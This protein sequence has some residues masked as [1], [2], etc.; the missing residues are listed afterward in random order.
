MIVFHTDL[1]N[2]L[3]YSYKHNIGVEKTCVEVYQGRNISFMTNESIK[4]LQYINKKILVVPTTTRTV[5]QY[6]R[7]NMGIGT[8]RYALVCNGGVLLVDGAEDIEW[9][10]ES[11]R[12]VLSS[13][14]ELKKAERLLAGDTDI[15]FEIRNIKNLFIFTK[16]NHPSGSVENLRGK[17]DLSLVDVFSNGIKVYIVPKTLNKGRSIKRLRKKLN[18][19]YVIAAGDS[20]FD[21]PML[22]EAEVSLA[23]SELRDK[24]KGSK[25]VFFHEDLTQIFSDALL[26]Y[27]KKKI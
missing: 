13:Q 25:D 17:L 2:T 3:I 21:I 9:T 27:I 16:S 11:G 26:R 15:S 5:E 22:N 12:L 24:L 10:Q 18:P 4:L 20:D 1:D 14:N 6:R 19:K 7:I 8:P 23:A